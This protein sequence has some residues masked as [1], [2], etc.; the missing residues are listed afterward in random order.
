MYLCW[1]LFVFWDLIFVLLSLP[2][3]LRKDTLDSV[4]VHFDGLVTPLRNSKM[5]GCL[6]FHLCLSFTVSEPLR[7]YQRAGILHSFPAQGPSF[8]LN[9]PLCKITPVELQMCLVQ[10]PVYSFSFLAFSL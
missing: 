6:F 4:H 7:C 3:P 8:H 10:F 5:P 1:I 2:S 9:L